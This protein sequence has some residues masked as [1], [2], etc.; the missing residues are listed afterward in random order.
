[1][2]EK[3]VDNCM[4]HKARFKEHKMKTC[5]LTLGQFM[6]ALKN[7]IEATVGHETVEDSDDVT[8]SLK[9]I[10]NITCKFEGPSAHK[11]HCTMLT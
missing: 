3:L 10:K 1:M 5:E 2:Q 6:D 8:E 9:R 4:N 7:K 11:V